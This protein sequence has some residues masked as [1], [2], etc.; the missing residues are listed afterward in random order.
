MHDNFNKKLLKQIFKFKNTTMHIN[1][2][3]HDQ[4]N[5]LNIYQEFL[6]LIV[7]S[8]KKEEDLKA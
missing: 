7:K 4:L 1:K 3:E 6:N 8:V 2:E 5:I